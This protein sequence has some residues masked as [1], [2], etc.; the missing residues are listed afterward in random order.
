M[1]GV[2]FRIQQCGLSFLIWL[3]LS[4]QHYDLCLCR[5]VAFGYLPDA[6]NK[7]GLIS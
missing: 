3:S 5:L 2:I 7:S 4:K 6:A 1:L